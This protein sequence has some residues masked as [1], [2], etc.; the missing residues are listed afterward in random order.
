MDLKLTNLTDKRNRTMTNDKLNT[1]LNKLIPSWL[2]NQS[3][4][5]DWTYCITSST[6][7]YYSLDSKDDVHA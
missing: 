4:S 3:F 2:S 5:M 6:D 1:S 7:K